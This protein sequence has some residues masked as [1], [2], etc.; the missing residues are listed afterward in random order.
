MWSSFGD[1]VCVACGAAEDGGDK[2][3]TT[4]AFEVNAEKFRVLHRCD[5]TIDWCSD[6]CYASSPIHL[7]AQCLN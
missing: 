7:H 1:D 4:V 5:R 3:T 2:V 6:L